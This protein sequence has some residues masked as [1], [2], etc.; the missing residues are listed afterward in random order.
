MVCMGNICRSP[1]AEGVFRQ[2]V[3][4]ASL[5]G[6][7]EVDSAGTSAYHVGEKAHAGTLRVLSRLGIAYEGR[8]RQIERDD[9]DRFDYVLAMDRENLS[10]IRRASAGSTAEIGLFLSY[11][12]AAGLVGIDE[13]PDPYYDNT[14]DQVYELVRRGCQALLD[15]IRSE[16]GF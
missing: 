6:K 16:R 15:Y 2:M 11:A 5:S 13:V 7:I 9:L 1:M 8:S 4:D 14:H 12:R 3:Q 10:Y